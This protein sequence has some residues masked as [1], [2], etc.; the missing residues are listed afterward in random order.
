MIDLKKNWTR[1]QI[2]NKIPMIK[3]NQK[4]KIQSMIF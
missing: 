3:K 4:M 2:K 1:N